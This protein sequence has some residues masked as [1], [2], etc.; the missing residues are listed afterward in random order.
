M[1]S[2]AEPNPVLIAAIVCGWLGDIFLMI[3]DPQNTRR[4]FKP[5]L[6][7]FLLG[8]VLYIAVFAAYLPRVAS[9]PAWGWGALA[10]YV[11]AGIVGYRLIAPHAGKMLPA[12][13]AYIIIIVLMGIS[14][15]LPLGSVNT[16]RRRY[17]HGRCVCIHGFRYPQRL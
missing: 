10:V 6:A 16:V 17:G 8:H 14:T 5:G 7:A 11:A 4:Y 12:I 15:V 1:A 3:P 2:A 9:V 13:I